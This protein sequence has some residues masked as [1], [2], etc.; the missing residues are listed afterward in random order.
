MADYANPHDM[1]A[2]GYERGRESTKEELSEART[3]AHLWRG[4]CRMQAARIR[5]V[6][7][8][9]E[10]PAGVLHD[11]KEYRDALRKY[12]EVEIL[13]EVVEYSQGLNDVEGP[14]VTLPIEFL[15][16]DK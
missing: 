15:P 12:V 16:K 11:L 9:K 6:L 2:L 13:R 7:A 8:G 4:L 10:T 14:G 1:Y 3:E 5:Y